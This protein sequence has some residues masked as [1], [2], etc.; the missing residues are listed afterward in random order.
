MHTLVFLRV[1]VRV[2]LCVST[3]RTWT[4]RCRACW[5]TVPQ[6]HWPTEKL[7]TKQVIACHHW[8]RGGALSLHA[9]A[10]SLARAITERP[11]APSGIAASMS[12]HSKTPYITPSMDVS[13]GKGVAWGAGCSSWDLPWFAFASCA[14][15]HPSCKANLSCCPLLLQNDTPVVKLL[16]C[17][18]AHCEPARCCVHVKLIFY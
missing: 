12:A 8:G 7:A 18:H 13:S 14:S 5:A 15:F 9:I 17:R 10:P 2:R 11:H 3:G 1:P 4:P 16:Q 6:R